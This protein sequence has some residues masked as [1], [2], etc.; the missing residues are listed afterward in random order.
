MSD[1]KKGNGIFSF[2]LRLSISMGL[3]FVLFKVL[4]IDVDKAIDLLKSANRI[5][6]MW[7]GIFFTACNFIIWW[8]WMIIMD[9]LGLKVGWFTAFRYHFLG[10]FGN[11]FLPSAVG[12]DI[13]KILGLC[14]VCGQKPRVVA[15]IVLDRMSGFGSIVLVA[16]IAF[17]FGYSLIGDPMLIIPIVGMIFGS[18]VIALILFNKKIFPFACK[19][20]NK[21]PKFKEAL[22]KMHDD[23]LLLKEEKVKGFQALGL[24][25]VSQC[26]FAISFFFIA[27]A[28]HADL[29]LV[30]FLIFVPMIAIISSMPSIGGV[31]VR[32][33]GGVFL[34]T[35]VGMASDVAFSVPFIISLFMVV[36][37]LIGG[38]IYVI[39]ISSGR[40]QRHSQNTG[41][42]G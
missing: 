42:S 3:L 29:A 18:V 6:L 12:G 14:K 9:A 24:S 35:K 39:T 21:L 11:L 7:A 26:I 19:L 34:F 23:F 38:F 5:D 8:R 2:V 32:E 17:L 13:I 40:V 15:S 22:I 16:T 28:L 20:F 27:K 1:K 25:C 30:Y 37:G 10:L 36:I 33:A 4:N 31:G 41:T